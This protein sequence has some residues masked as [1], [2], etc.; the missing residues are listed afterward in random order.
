MSDTALHDGEA[1]LRLA[2]IGR[3]GRRGDGTGDGDRETV[4]GDGDR[5]TVSKRN[6]IQTVSASL[7]TGYF[8]FAKGLFVFSRSM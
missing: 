3:G 2:D 8:L 6:S 4:A 7:L 5:E 1:I